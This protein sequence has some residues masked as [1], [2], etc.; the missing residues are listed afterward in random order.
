MN[1]W[2]E[3]VD[4]GPAEGSNFTFLEKVNFPMTRDNNEDWLPVLIQDSILHDILIISTTIVI[5]VGI[6]APTRGS[7]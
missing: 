4:R 5:F 7:I 6:Q 3:F 2:G 1:W